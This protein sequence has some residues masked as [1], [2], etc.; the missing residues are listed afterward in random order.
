MFIWSQH[1]GG[2]V[3]FWVFPLLSHYVLVYLGTVRDIYSTRNNQF[4]DESTI[5]TKN[6]LQCMKKWVWGTPNKIKVLK[7]M[8]CPVLAVFYQS[9]SGNLHPPL[10]SFS[11]PHPPRIV[12]SPNHQTKWEVLL[13]QLRDLLEVKETDNW[14]EIKIKT[15]LMQRQKVY[16]FI[17]EIIDQW[18]TSLAWTVFSFKPKTY[19]FSNAPPFSF[20]NFPDCVHL[21]AK[22]TVCPL[23]LNI[24]KDNLK[25]LWIDFERNVGT[26]WSWT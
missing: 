2:N 18:K 8:V 25:W 12:F 23:V 7:V 9:H 5:L 14:E 1:D 24:D 4:L 17:T 13:A 3:C 22:S 16:S 15:K 11:V 20:F 21:W 10:F 26:Y 19:F 6:Y